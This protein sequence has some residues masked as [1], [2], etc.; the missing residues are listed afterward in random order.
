MRRKEI[1]ALIQRQ[2][3]I[4]FLSFRFTLN[5]NLNKIGNWEHFNYTVSN[6]NRCIY[7]TISIKLLHLRT[8]THL[9]CDQINTC[10]LVLDLVAMISNCLN[11]IN[12]SPSH[13]EMRTKTNLVCLLFQSI[14]YRYRCTSVY[15]RGVYQNGI[16][17]LMSKS[18]T[19]T[20]SNYT[21]TSEWFRSALI[22]F[23]IYWSL[24]TNSR[25]IFFLKITWT[26]THSTVYLLCIQYSF[27]LCFFEYNLFFLNKWTNLAFRVR[28]NI[29]LWQNQTCFLFL[30]SFLFFNL[31]P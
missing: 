4:V 22:H 27:L 28:V 1:N 18:R 30:I 20:E 16:L 21:K 29:A 5:R 2:L 17:N 13:S 31:L 15:R 3:T 8:F 7:K 24:S 6:A 19:Q 26:H 23:T 11:V 9:L 12:C 14:R 10:F 25:C